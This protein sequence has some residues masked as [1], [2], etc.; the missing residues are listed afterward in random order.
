MTGSNTSSPGGD[1]SSTTEGTQSESTVST[2]KVEHLLS[3][4]SLQLTVHKLNGSNYLEWAQSI[5]LAIDIRGKL[6]YL[7]GEVKQPAAGDPNL[8]ALRSDN[9]L[10]IAWLINSMELAIGK[11]HLF[12]PTAKEVWEAVRDMYSN[13]KNSSQIFELK[14][15]LWKSKQGDRDVTSYYNE[16][17]PLWQELDLC[18]EDE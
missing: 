10:T 18:Y 14:T 15:K 12:L 17:V 11:P 16:I 7:T 9:S 8:K 5:K 3:N 1:S 4:L 2:S 13:V 6:G